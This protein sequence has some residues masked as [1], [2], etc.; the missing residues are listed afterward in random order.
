MKQEISDMKNDF[1]KSL[2]SLTLDIKDKFN[3]ISDK[4][5]TIKSAFKESLI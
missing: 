3:N 5:V 1:M 4:L 2:D